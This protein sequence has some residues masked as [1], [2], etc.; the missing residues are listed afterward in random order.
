VTSYR[1]KLPAAAA[2]G[3]YRGDNS[4][5]IVTDSWAE[6]SGDVSTSGSNAVTIGASKVAPSMMKSSTV[7]AQTDGATITWAIGSVL[8]AQASVTL[9][10]NRTLAITN[11][12][13]GGN[14]WIKLTQDGTGSRTLTLGSGCTWKVVNGGAGAIT[15][16]TTASAI[17]V[18]AFTYDGTN[19]LATLGKNFN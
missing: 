7:D 15:L 8:N 17:D 14:Y 16:T 1:I 18:L 2:T 19:C 3:I 11:P 9:G 5:G 12:V 6:L 10:G 4:A 13:I